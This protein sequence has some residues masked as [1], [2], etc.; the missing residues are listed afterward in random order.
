MTS[1]FADSFYYIALLNPAD[2]YHGAAIEATRALSGPVLTTAWVLTEVA[3]ALCAPS[4]RGRTHALLRRVLADSNTTVIV[5]AVPW[6]ERGVELYGRR[7]DKSWS[8][9]DCISFE[10]MGG[11]GLAEALT[12]DH[13]FVQ[14]GF[15]AL[16]APAGSR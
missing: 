5:D 15:S 10:V 13:H 1:V 16:L 2:R 3:D 4:V 12:A 8:L 6:L 7:S 9:T 11:H 14:A